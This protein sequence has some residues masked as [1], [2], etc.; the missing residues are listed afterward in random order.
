MESFFRT[1]D[2]LVEHVKSPVRRQL[3]DEIN[4]EDRLIAIKGTRG[5]GKTTFLLQYARERY[6]TSRACLYVNMN[7]FYFATHSLVEFA[8]TFLDRGGRVLLLD[9]I[10]KYTDWSRDLRACY[11]RYPRLRI[12]FTSNSALS[13]EQDNPD[14]EGIVHCYNLRGFSFREYL[15][16]RTGYRYAPHTLAEI[17]SHHEELT[18]EVVRDIDPMGYFEEYLRCGFYPFCLEKG[19]FTENLLKTMNMMIELDILFVKLIDQTYLGRIKK[20]LCLLAM[21][22]EML[23]ISRLSQEIETSRATVMNYIQYLY[24]ARLINLLYQK[25]TAS[26][27][28]PTRVLL[29]NSNL[30]Y[31]MKPDPDF[32]EVMETFFMNTLM[33]DHWVSVGDKT[34]TFWVDR[35]H[36]FQLLREGWTNSDLKRSGVHYV[37]G[38]KCM[39]SSDILPL[40]IFGFLY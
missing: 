2:N 1:H 38:H 26:L 40:W 36:R 5:V 4:W 13:V 39:G 17:L 21:D 22:G 3:M 33:K 12:V 37:S 10:F 28:K 18:K 6:G 30:L 25:E 16:L 8:G 27:K 29:H 11:E 31:C 9:Q 20:L 24:D 23:N 19:N 35:E 34:C 14:L 32:Y 7:N 15:N